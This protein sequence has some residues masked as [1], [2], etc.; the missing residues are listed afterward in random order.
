VLVVDDLGLQRGDGCFETV[1]VTDADGPSVPVHLDAHLDRLA[2]SAATLGIVPPSRGDWNAAVRD[3]V[4][5][6]SEPGEAV[7]K[8]LLTRGVPGAGPTALVTVSALP[9]ALLRQRETGVSVVTLSRG[10]PRDAHAGAPWLLGAVKTLSYAVNMAALREAARR[11]A[12]DVVFVSSDGWVLEAPTASVVWSSGGR[13]LTTPDGDSGILVGTTQRAV[14]AAAERAGIPTGYEFATPADLAGSEAVW[15][16]SGVRG[17]TSVHTIDGHPLP[18]DPDL[19]GRLR[20]VALGR[21][22]DL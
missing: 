3:A 17:I 1:L 14:F 8:L 4:D 11:G 7:L 21:K 13:L 6:W 10:M 9:D 20:A 19:T 15:L 16:A 12:E 5:A 22:Q 2:R 18:V